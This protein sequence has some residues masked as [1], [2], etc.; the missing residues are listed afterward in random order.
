MT[1]FHLHKKLGICWFG[2]K[3]LKL[4]VNNEPY[5]FWIDLGPVQ[6]TWIKVT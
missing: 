6:I 1:E 4:S 5:A 2:F 3:N